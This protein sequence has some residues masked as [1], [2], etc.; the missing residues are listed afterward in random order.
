M[1]PASAHVRLFV[2]D[3]LSELLGRLQWSVRDYAR[4]ELPAG[5]GQRLQGASAQ[6]RFLAAGALD[7]HGLKGSTRLQAGDF[8]LL[9]RGDDYRLVN[10]GPGGATVFGG[11]LDYDRSGASALEAVLPEL[12]VAC[13][14]VLREPLAASMLETM[15]QELCAGRPGSAVLVSRF[16]EVV[17][18]AAIRV[19]LESGCDRPAE[20]LVTLRDPDI[21]RTVAALR[22]EP[23]A[24]WTI[25]R[26][27][28]IARVSRS[29]FAERFRV[30]MG[31]P[32]ARYLARMRMELARELLAREGLTV[33]QTASRLGYG[34]EEAFSRAFRRHVGVAPGAWRKAVAV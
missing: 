5:G 23:G 27:A 12:L 24:D 9:L 16:A 15:E 2:T 31:E 34:S 22:A 10:S 11:V 29:I 3:P 33:L 8:L 4:T 17:A 1:P 6:F 25:A 28:L 18:T 21:L 7:V 19:W 26:M 14:F 13:R 20:W 30:A 32:P